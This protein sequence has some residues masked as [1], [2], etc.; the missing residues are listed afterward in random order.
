[1][2]ISGIAGSLVALAITLPL[3]WKWELGVRRVGC[4]VLAMAIVV[5]EVVATIDYTVE[6][7]ASVRTLLVSV[8]TL[9]V[10]LAVLAWRFYRDPERRPPS[11]NDA[12]VSPADGEVVYVRTSHGGRLPVAT[13]HGRDYELIE[14]T[15]TPLRT[16][17]VVVVGIAMSFLDVHVNRSPI[18]GRVALRRHFPGRFGSL[19][20]PEM[21]FEN[22][23]ATT[24][25]E[26]DGLEVAVV[27]IASRLVRQIAGFVEPGDD[28]D[29]GQRIGVI[30]L[31]S[32]VDV[33]LPKL[34]GL[35]VDVRPGD[36]VRA[37]ESVLASLPA[38]RAVPDR[39]QR[40]T[41]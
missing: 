15:K 41:A 24:V 38:V 3:A 4:S 11:R 25:I 6:L 29:L 40:L 20:R 8:I 33:V 39:Q 31:G 37:G 5:T 23:R 13:K 10:A 18:A 35:E 12:V 14:L 9:L 36:R 1:M 16:Q 26:R 7:S 28:V 30:R 19:G 2:L 32:Q 22:E 34:P 27:Q 17:E 21:V